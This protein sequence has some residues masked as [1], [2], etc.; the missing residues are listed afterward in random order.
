MHHRS[1]RGN[2]PGREGLGGRL[3]GDGHRG[4]PVW[5]GFTRRRWGDE[6]CF[7][8]EPPTS[9]GWRSCVQT[10]LRPKVRRGGGLLYGVVRAST[11]FPIQSG[12]PRFAPYPGC[13]GTSV[14]L[15][16][17]PR[18]TGQPDVR[19]SR[20][21]T[22]RVGNLSHSTG[23]LRAT[24]GSRGDRINWSEFTTNGPRGPAGAARKE[25]NHERDCERNYGQEKEWKQLVKCRIIS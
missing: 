6:L 23:E 11:G 13:K 15:P 18:S 3:A 12:P 9:T 5:R 24:R 17:I 8:I 14:V 10:F 1:Q 20:T 19:P 4:L 16:A 7:H 21:L 22:G 25:P 2:L